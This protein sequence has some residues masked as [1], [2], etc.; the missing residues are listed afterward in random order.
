VLAKLGSLFLTHYLGNK[1]YVHTKSAVIRRETGIKA[2]ASSFNRQVDT[3]LQLRSSIPQYRREPVPSK[4]DL[5]NI[6][7]VDVFSAL[8]D[9]WGLV[10]SDQGDDRWK[11]DGE[12]REAI[13]LLLEIDRC[14]EERERLDWEVSQLAGWANSVAV[15]V[16]VAYESIGEYLC[17]FIC[18]FQWAD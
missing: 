5:K 8:W 10:S 18:L 17:L 6:F 9:E 3:M 13:R 16:A 7:Q 15:K 12:M 1:L 11:T 14:K 4:I 2:I